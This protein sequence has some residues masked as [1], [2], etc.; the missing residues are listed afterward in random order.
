MESPNC[1]CSKLARLLQ[2]VDFSLI[3]NCPFLR[4]KLWTILLPDV[5]HFQKYILEISYLYSDL[6]P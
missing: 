6:L 2:K 5:S 3:E 4:Q 1:S